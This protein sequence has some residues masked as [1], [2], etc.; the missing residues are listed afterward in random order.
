MKRILTGD[1]PTSDRFHLGNYYGKLDNTVKLQDEYEVFIPLVDLHALTTHYDRTAD[2]G[3]NIK[4]LVL[5]Y[6]AVGLDPSKVT[7]FVQSGVPEI[8][9]IAYFLSTL[10]PRSIIAK[11]PALKEK[12]DQGNQDTVALFYYPVLMAADILSFKADLVPVGKDQKPHV[13]FARDIA[14]K[15]NNQFG[16]VFSYPEA[17]IGGENIT[18]PGTDGQEKMGK[19]LGNAIFLS[20]SKEE[21]EKKVMGMYTDPNRLKATDPGTVEGNPVFIYLD[22]FADKSDEDQINQLKTRYREG[23]VGDVEVKQFLIKVLNGFLEPIRQKRAELEAQPGLV[24]KILQE[25]TIRARAEAQKILKEIKKNMHLNYFDAPLELSEDGVKPNI[26]IDDFSRSDIKVGTVLLAE[27]VE[28]SEKLIKLEIDLGEDK[29]RHVLTGMKS[30]FEPDYF[31]GKQIT[32]IANLEPRKMMGLESQGMVL[33]ADGD[34]PILLVPLE[35]VANGAK[36]K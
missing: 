23:S 8:L 22:A 25:G 3:A 33:A 34:K 19:S 12:L 27:A 30:Y 17:L 26:T 28:G 21:V 16:K 15:F 31:V 11:Q 32:V 36:I 2:L 5:E 14:Q 4:S 9:E 10:T 29:P 20:D 6:L 7:F 1:R 24:D 18:L 13:E 35:N